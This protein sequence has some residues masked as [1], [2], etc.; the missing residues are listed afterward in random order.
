M[1]SK[2]ADGGGGGT[3][4]IDHCSKFSFP[5]KGVPTYVPMNLNTGELLTKTNELAAF[6]RYMFRI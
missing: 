6:F 5:V 4:D 3:R 2:R 1:G